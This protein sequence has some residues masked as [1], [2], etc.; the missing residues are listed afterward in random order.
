[1][2]LKIE[3]ENSPSSLALDCWLG[4][5][6]SSASFLVTDLGPESVV[7]G[8]PWLRSVNPEID[9]AEGTMRVGLKERGRDEVGVER[10]A[11]NRTQ[12]R[13]WWRNGVLEDPSGTL[14]CAAG[15]TYSTELAEEASKQKLKR[16]FEEIVPE[17][18]R[19]YAKVFLETESERLPEHKPY[20]HCID[21]KPETPETLR[22]KVFPMPL[23][24]QGELDRFLEDNLRKGYI[25]PSK[26]LIASPVFFIKKKDGQLR[27]V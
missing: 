10:V 13:R 25:I 9:W 11:A 16:T 21:L 8:L 19:R 3:P 22:S 24:E 17:D 5:S 18:Y 12:C 23:N 26:S 1:M 6:R 27:L 7:L 14:W 4:S 2:D 15:Y 20:D